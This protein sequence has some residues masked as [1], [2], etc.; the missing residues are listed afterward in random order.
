MG[1]PDHTKNLLLRQAVESWSS[2]H[3]LRHD[4]YIFTNQEKLKTE[5]SHPADNKFY[6]S[7]TNTMSW[8]HSRGKSA[9]NMQLIPV[10]SE[11]A[12]SY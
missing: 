5:Y 6:R 7:K 8:N 3:E 11:A 9:L 10:K 12:Q 2:I 1:A 4:A